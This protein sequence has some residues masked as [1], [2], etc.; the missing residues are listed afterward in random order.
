MYAPEYLVV[1]PEVPMD[2]PSTGTPKDNE[3]TFT[4]YANGLGA[5]I[6]EYDTFTVLMDKAYRA[7]LSPYKIFQI[8]GIPEDLITAHFGGASR[9]EIE[10]FLGAV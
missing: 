4:A 1:H 2:Q 3:E 8:T 9:G 7:N 10:P 6:R 5:S